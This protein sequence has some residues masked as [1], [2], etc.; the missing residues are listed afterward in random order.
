MRVT[1]VLAQL[2][3]CVGL[4][5]ASAQTPPAVDPIILRDMGSFHVGGREVEVTGKPVKEVT[6]TPGGVPVKVDPNGTYVVEAMYAQYFLPT[7]RRAAA[8]GRC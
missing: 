1:L 3:F 6:L 5:G 2:L 8:P 4:S 7:P